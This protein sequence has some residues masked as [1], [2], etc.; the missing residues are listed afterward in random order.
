MRLIGTGGTGDTIISIGR[1]SVEYSQEEL[2]QLHKDLAKIK[3]YYKAEIE[4]LSS[5]V[6]PLS[7]WDKIYPTENSQL[8]WEL[9][10]Y[11]RLYNAF[12]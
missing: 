2:E 3:S 8:N 6:K 1:K 7:L 12:D 5:L 9:E 10:Q 4:R 11:K